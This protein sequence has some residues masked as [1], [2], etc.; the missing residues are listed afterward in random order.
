MG[1]REAGAEG[2][3]VPLV[4]SEERLWHPGGS[5]QG[6]RPSE[7]SSPSG[8]GAGLLEAARGPGTPRLFPGP[9]SVFGL[10]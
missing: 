9:G 1:V 5:E 3:R 8:G 2:L 7:G 10:S 6:P 4:G